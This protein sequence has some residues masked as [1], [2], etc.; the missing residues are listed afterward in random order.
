MATPTSVEEYMA[1]LPEASRT[2]LEQLRKTIKAAAPEATE[3]I[4]R[5][6]RERAGALPL[7]KG[8]DPLPAR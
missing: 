2:P 3:T 4:S 1:G 8:N 5:G 6:M 7:R